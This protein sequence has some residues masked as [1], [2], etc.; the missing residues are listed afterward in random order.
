MTPETSTAK[1]ATAPKHEDFKAK[2]ESLGIPFEKI[3]VFGALRLNIHVTCKSR[4]TADRWAL[5]LS[6]IVKGASIK[7]IP[8]S[9]EAKKNLGTNLLPTRISGFRVYVAG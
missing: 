8:T 2:L 4:N 9:W 1:A 5:T 6:S 3:Y 7:T